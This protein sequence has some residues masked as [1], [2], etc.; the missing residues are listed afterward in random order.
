MKRSFKIG[1]KTL[2]AMLLIASGGSVSAGQWA[3]PDLLLTAEQVN[4]NLDKPD[5][6]VVDCRRLKEYVAGH[7]PGSI[8]LGDRCRSVL[9]DSTSRVYRD[10][11]KYEKLFGTVGI[12]NDTHVVFYGGDIG[13][14][15]DATVG[16]WIMEY[17]GHDKVH[18]LN[19]GI[20]AWRKAGYRLDNKLV[21][22]DPKTF[23]ANVVASR[24]GETDEVLQ[25]ASG[26][27]KDQL[28]DSRTKKEFDGKDIRAIRGGHV[29]NVTLNVS[30]KDTLAHEK[31][32]KTGKM[33]PVAYLDPNAAEK[34]FGSLDK[35]KRTL[36]YCQTGTRSTM[37]YLQLRALGFKDVAN[38][39]ES[40]R[41]WGS[42]LDYP[43]AGEQWFNFAGLNNKIR[44]LEKKVADMEK[45]TAKK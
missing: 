39:D 45:A 4:A 34:A 11:S 27:K 21:K 31:N 10:V 20:D 13:S 28:V 19:G 5:W 32:P 35:S 18:V 38:W 16:F 44:T 29:P 1:T 9:R 25:I 6:V 14:L 8:S 30:H 17:L 12:G 42:Q 41:V 26:E 7:I 40:W 23:K 43:V 22:K 33:E 3:N 37:T 24:Y 15:L 36:A 2:L